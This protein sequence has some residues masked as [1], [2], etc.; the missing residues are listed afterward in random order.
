MALGR[1]D[2]VTV[3]DGLE[4][5][6]KNGGSSLFRRKEPCYGAVARAVASHKRRNGIQEPTPS[7]FTLRDWFRRWERSGR[8][9]AALV[10]LN[11]RK[12]RKPTELN[13]SL[14][15]IYDAA[16]KKFYLQEE[17]IGVRTLHEYLSGRIEEHNRNSGDRLTPLTETALHR[18][19]QRRYTAREIADARQGKRKGAMQFVA[20]RRRPTPSRL[21]DIVE[22]DHALL[23]VVVTRG[24]NGQPLETESDAPIQ[25]K[26]IAGRPWLTVAVCAA[27]R[28]V[29]GW[30]ISLEPPSYVSVMQCLRSMLSP[31][32]DVTVNGRIVENPCFGLPKVLKVDN[33]KEFHSQA[34]K[35]AAAQLDFEILYCPRR[36]PWEKGRVE[37][38][39]GEVQRNFASIPGRTFQSPEKRGDYKPTDRA[40]IEMPALREMFA[41]W[42]TAYYHQHNHR[43]L[44]NRTPREVWQELSVHGVYMPS[45]AKDVVMLT[46]L[47]LHKPNRDQGIEY[48]GLHWDS[49]ELEKLRNDHGL[50]RK[51]HC[52]LDPLNLAELRVWDDTVQP[53]VPLRV[54]CQDLDLIQGLDLDMWKRTRHRSKERTPADEIVR[55]ETVAD[56]R[57]ELF[58][59]ATREDEGGKPLSKPRQKFADGARN[60]GE[61][62]VVQPSRRVD[63]DVVP[64]AAAAAVAVAVAVHIPGSIATR[65]QYYD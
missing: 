4:D 64:A 11:D 3:I 12:G 25:K 19:I 47:P 63:P 62:A 58:E 29:V 51:W 1:W 14:V 34:L 48:L 18:F 38:F 23:D 9:P 61:G 35:A 27:S 36:R 41:I 44:Y 50:K 30:S 26:G 59:R 42:I 2:Y 52:V 6:R 17:R 40:R 8:E 39:F 28:C 33:G 31:K 22:I 37:R 20:K 57:M 10:P 13:P 21:C 24:R 65:S 54:P 16:V 7:P 56:A 49:D 43:N 32:P 5:R 45:K 46:G 53:N 55:R 15:S 60:A